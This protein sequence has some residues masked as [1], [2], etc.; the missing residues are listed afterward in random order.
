[1]P[2]KKPSPGSNAA[3]S[4]KPLWLSAGIVPILRGPEPEF[5]LLRVYDYWDFPKGMVEKGEDPFLAAQRELVEETGLT[6]VEFPWGHDFFET[7]PYRGGKVARYYVGEVFSKNVVFGI[8]PELGHAEH[9]EFRWCT[10]NQASPLLGPRVRAVLEWAGS[11]IL[12]KT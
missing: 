4:S 6:K 3:P 2:T 9:H 5:L 10:Q 12:K 11:H 7:E 8:N 1:M